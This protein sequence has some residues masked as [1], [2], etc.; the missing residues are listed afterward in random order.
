MRVAGDANTPTGIGTTYH[1]GG[2]NSTDVMSLSRALPAGSGEPL[3]GDSTA[4]APGSWDQTAMLK[5]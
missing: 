4:T 1:L 3:P 2:W 5:D